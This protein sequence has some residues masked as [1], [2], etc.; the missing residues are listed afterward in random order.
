MLFGETD[1]F[2]FADQILTLGMNV[3]VIEE[4]GVIDARSG[5]GFHDFTRAR[6]TAG[7]Q[8]QFVCAVGQYKLGTFKF[9]GFDI[10]HGFDVRHKK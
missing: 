8:Q 6:R 2:L 7:V 10:R 1:V 5:E 3:G 9:C 4:N